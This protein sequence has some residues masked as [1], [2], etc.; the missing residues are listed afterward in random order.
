[1]TIHLVIISTPITI[2]QHSRLLAFINLQYVHLRICIYGV[3]NM[4]MF[5][6]ATILYIYYYPIYISHNISLP[7]SSFTLLSYY[8]PLYK[9]RVIVAS[10]LYC[11]SCYH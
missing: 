5:M 4:H 2:N 1:M 11:Y 6:H 3:M 9:Y 10:Y 8:I 7:S